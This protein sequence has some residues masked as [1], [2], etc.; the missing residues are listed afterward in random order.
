MAVTVLPY[1]GPSPWAILQ[2]HLPFIV[3][4]LQVVGHQEVLDL[5]MVLTPADLVP[6]QVLVEQVVQE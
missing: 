1:Q 5:V 6:D 2:A 3:A 4:F